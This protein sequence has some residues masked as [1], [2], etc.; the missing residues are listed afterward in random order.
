MEPGERDKRVTNTANTH[1]LQNTW[2]DPVARG[3]D[4]PPMPEGTRDRERE[5]V[6]LYTRG[7]P[8]RKETRPHVINVTG[9]YCLAFACPAVFVPRPVLS[10]AVS[11]RCLDDHS[12]A[13][14]VFYG[15]GLSRGVLR[16]HRHIGGNS[17][18]FNSRNRPLRQ[19]GADRVG[20]GLR[21]A[22]FAP[23]QEPNWAANNR[24]FSTHRQ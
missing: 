15:H 21:A 6:D 9:A 20:V 3:F 23:K 16:V 4:S 2:G 24:L 14:K 13:C 11:G 17:L 5:R 22:R 10:V 18:I 7:T 19:T 1:S 8:H 12:D